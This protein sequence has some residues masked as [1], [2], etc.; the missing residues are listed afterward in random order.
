MCL[1]QVYDERVSLHRFL[2]IRDGSRLG[3]DSLAEWSAGPRGPSRPLFDKLACGVLVQNG[4]HT[5]AIPLERHKRPAVT[6][7]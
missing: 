6:R 3:C 2:A 7:P 4:S 1:E 5:G